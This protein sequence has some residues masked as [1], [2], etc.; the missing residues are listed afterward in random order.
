M[1]RRLFGDPNGVNQY[2]SHM[3]LVN[4][5]ALLF[6]LVVI[7]IMK[8]NEVFSDEEGRFLIMDVTLGEQRITLVNLYGPNKDDTTFFY[9][10][11]GSG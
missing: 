3:E 9:K 11:D 10:F 2:G 7:F 6:L 5:Q 4:L 8:F 1:L